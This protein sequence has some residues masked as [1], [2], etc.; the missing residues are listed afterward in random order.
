MVL[1]VCVWKGKSK[2][3]KSDQD[4][5]KCFRKHPKVASLQAGLGCGI[6]TLVALISHAFI[7][8]VQQHQVQ[9]SF[10][11][12]AS[13]FTDRRI[14][15]AVAA[16]G[17]NLNRR[18]LQPRLPP[19]SN[20]CCL[21][22]EEPDEPASHVSPRQTDRRTEGRTD[23]PVI[24]LTASGLLLRPWLSWAQT[25]KFRLLQTEGA[26]SGFQVKT[27]QRKQ[28][29]RRSRRRRGEVE[30]RQVKGETTGRKLAPRGCWEVKKQKLWRGNRRRLLFFP[31]LVS[32]TT[33]PLIQVFN[34][35]SSFWFTSISWVRTASVVPGPAWPCLSR[36]SEC[37][38]VCVF[39][40]HL[41]IHLQIAGHVC[42]ANGAS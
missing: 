37:V 31:F 4:E 42:C 15:A 30:Q 38:C 19:P 16:A 28:R 14:S 17:A 21:L 5:D 32:G 27:N 8:Q 24:Q 41:Q 23:R 40:Y 25:P 36:N 35:S 20:S 6:V 29:R 10:S 2:G 18:L 39:S 1:C 34:V 26:S 11:R 3:E 7:M 33:P 13:E 12:M 22:S 9:H